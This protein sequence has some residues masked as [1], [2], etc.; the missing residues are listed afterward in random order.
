MNACSCFNNAILKACKKEVKYKLGLDES[1]A[2]GDLHRRTNWFKLGDRVVGGILDR[3][4]KG[5]LKLKL[6]DDDDKDEEIQIHPGEL[7]NTGKVRC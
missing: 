2:E 4:P 5:Y 6:V 7:V 3:V 1:S